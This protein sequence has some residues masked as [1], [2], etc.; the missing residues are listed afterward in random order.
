MNQMSS[1]NQSP[2]IFLKNITKIENGHLI[3]KGWAGLGAQLK[4]ARE[5]VAPWTSQILKVFVDHQENR[6][7]V[8]FAW[9]TEK[10]DPHS[11]M[12]IL[13]FD[14][15]EK[16]FEMNQ[17]CEAYGRGNEVIPSLDAKEGNKP[18]FMAHE[19]HSLQ[20]PVA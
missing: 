14:N 17:V 16:I 1:S 19:A 9:N 5:A 15:I 4:A 2:S 6:A 11:T 13:R 12:A 10:T 3:A 18:T 20:A 7:V 8:H